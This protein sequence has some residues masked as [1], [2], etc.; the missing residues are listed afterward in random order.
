MQDINGVSEFYTNAYEV[1]QLFVFQMV[2]TSAIFTEILISC[3]AQNIL[4]IYLY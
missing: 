3:L 2:I 4:T 1:K